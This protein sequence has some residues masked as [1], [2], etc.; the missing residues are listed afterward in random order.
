M[1]H[2]ANARHGLVLLLA[3]S[4][5]S[6]ASTFTPAS[7]GRVGQCKVSSQSS[8]VRS[9]LRR[10]AQLRDASQ[11][12]PG[13]IRIEGPAPEERQ[14]LKDELMRALQGLDRGFNANTE[15]RK[16]ASIT[17]LARIH[18]VETLTPGL[19]TFPGC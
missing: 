15:Q 14:R 1:A 2:R 5:F 7:V 18:A 9:S 16:V 19:R 12:A 6:T 4:I 13:E 8:I 11:P 10:V 3:S 17:L